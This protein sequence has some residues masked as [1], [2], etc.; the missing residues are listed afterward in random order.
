MHK[1][2]FSYVYIILQTIASELTLAKLTPFTLHL[3]FFI[4]MF[5]FLC[6]RERQRASRGGEERQRQ[7][8]KMLSYQ[9]RA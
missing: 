6:L 7:N 2:L 4:F 5:Y 3:I 8:L 9:H 1:L